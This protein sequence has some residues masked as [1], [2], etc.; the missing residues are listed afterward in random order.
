MKRL[1]RENVKILEGGKSIDPLDPTWLE[2]LIV[3][4][5]TPYSHG[6]IGGLAAQG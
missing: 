5:K 2:K 6:Y 4:P 3:K 1:S